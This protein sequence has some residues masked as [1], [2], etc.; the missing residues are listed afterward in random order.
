MTAALARDVARS[1]R[2]FL[3]ERAAELRAVMRNRAGEVLVK[4]PNLKTNPGG[5]R[6][7]HLLMWLAYAFAGESGRAGLARLFEPPELRRLIGAYDFVLF[8]RNRLHF[9]TGRREDVLHI[10]YQP[11]AADAFG[12]RG[13]DQE[14][15]TRLM[16]RYYEK[17]TDILVLLLQAVDRLTLE[18]LAPRRRPAATPGCFIADGKLHVS[19]AADAADPVV[20]RARRA[21]RVRAGAGR[22]FQL[23]A[24]AAGARGAR[25]RP[26]R[27]APRGAAGGR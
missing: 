7:V 2:R 9:H 23:A 22:A 14:K 1:R 5:L 11:L 10:G 19:R 25:A 13:D 18:H 21:A 24:L 3:R 17:A 8:N 15:A 6:S 20:R 16:R 12:I 27:A 4:E 26:A